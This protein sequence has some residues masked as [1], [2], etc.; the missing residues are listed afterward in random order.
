MARPMRS[1]SMSQTITE[2]LN[3]QKRKVD[4]DTYDIS[5]QQ[6]LAMVEKAQIDIAP[7]YQRHFRWDEARQSLYIESIFL[8]IPVPSLFMAANAD[9]TWELVDG[10]QRLNTL[11]HFAG[12]QAALERAGLAGPLRLGDLEKLGTFSGRTFSEL[13]DSV[14]LQFQLK[15][16]KVI[17]ITDKSDLAVRFDVFERLNTGGVAL[18]PQEIRSCVYRGEFN[19]FIE[20]LAQMREFRKVAKLPPK[21]QRDGTPEEWVLRFFAYLD[22]YKAFDH[23]V[24]DFL[25]GYMQDANRSFDF[26]AKRKVFERTFKHLATMFPEGIKRKKGR[27]TPV[28]LFEGVAVGAAIALTS[29]GKINKPAS[30]AWLESEELRAA[31]TAASN[32][33]KNVRFRIEYCA[34]QFG[35]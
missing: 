21:Q 35:A 29:K 16:V 18:S 20:K 17:T 8:G 28:N 27:T 15:P 4:Y 26:S 33:P 31:T 30:G 7:A 24:I 25:N 32:T 3:E 11:V 1:E 5:V 22:R 2:Q 10:V 19:D 13:P 23:S 34:K 9:G 14:R 6:L 12:S